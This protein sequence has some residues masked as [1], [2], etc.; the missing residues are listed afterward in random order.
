MASLS[1][2]KLL[3]HAAVLVAGLRPSQ[4]RLQD[5]R[6]HGNMMPRPQVPKVPMENVGPVVSRNGTELPPYDTVYYFDQL[7]GMCGVLLN[8]PDT[9]HDLRRS[10]QPRIGHVP[11]AL[12]AHV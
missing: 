10:Q 3:L 4:A 8:D 2:R 11:A 5:G 9:E 6:A 1:A 12:L 7:I